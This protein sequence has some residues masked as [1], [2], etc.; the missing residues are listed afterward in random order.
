MHAGQKDLKCA[1][2]SLY[3]FFRM[4]PFLGTLLIMT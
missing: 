2:I 3:L 1:T 4:Q